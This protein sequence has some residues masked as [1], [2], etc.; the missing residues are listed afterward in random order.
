MKNFKIALVAVL[1]LVGFNM[2][3]QDENNPWAISFGVNAIDFHPTGYDGNLN[4]AGDQAGVFDEYFNVGDHYNVIPAVSTVRVGRYLND[5]FSLQFGAN[6]NKLTKVGNNPETNPGNHAVL[7]LD[8]ALKYNLQNLTGCTKLAQPYVQGGGSYTFFDW[9]G[10]GTLDGGL[11]INFWLHE[12]VAFFVESQYKHS[13]DKAYAP[14]FQHTAGIA[15]KFGGTDTDGDGI[16]D[17][18]DACPNDFGLEAFNGCPDSDSDG[19]M[20]SED[21][22]PNTAGI[23]EFNGCPDTDGDGIADNND[24]CPKVAGTKANKGCPDSDNDGVIDSKDSCPNKK[25][26]KANKGCP[27]PDTDGDG[28]L[29]KDDACP[30]VKGIKAEKGC[31]KKVVKETISVEAKA[32]LD[33]YAKT[34]YFN[35]GKDSFKSGVTTK[36]DAIAEIMKEFGDANFL[37]EGHTDSQGSKTLN[38]NLSDKRAAAVVSYLI[39]KGIDSSRL[40]SVGFGEDYPIADNNT[41]AGRAQNRRVEINL[42][43]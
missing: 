36:L 21:K 12:N 17:N 22:C 41:K 20:D 28:I 13:F 8:A 14:F 29:D 16:F 6:V 15:V 39:G 10:T 18:N 35:S 31:P 1:I 30:K 42:R 3:A 40:T 23:A 38:Q 9:E 19:I 4:D 26:P 5:G 24:S 32:K 25:G 34:I 37:V 33:A 2:N 7:G 11:G 27:W 43:K